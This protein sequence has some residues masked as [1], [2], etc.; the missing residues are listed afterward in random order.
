MKIYRIDQNS[1]KK[2]NDLITDR[3]YSLDMVVR[4]ERID[5]SDADGWYTADEDGITGLLTF[6]IIGGEMEILSL[7]SLKENAGIGTA[8]LDTAV[9]EARDKGIERI[10]LITTND[11]IRALR[12]YQKFGFDMCGFFRNALDRSRKLKPEIPLIGT[13]GIPLKHE[14]EMELFV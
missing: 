11:N 7:D 5:L 12:F 14:I 2:I 3:W 1:R 6:R 9:S 4:G 10:V 13:D 8:L